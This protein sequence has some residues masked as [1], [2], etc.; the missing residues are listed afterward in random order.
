MGA[1]FNDLF[2]ASHVQAVALV[3]GGQAKGDIGA[4]RGQGFDQQ[5][6][7]RL[8]VGV[9]IAPDGDPFALLDS[10]AQALN[11]AVEIGQGKG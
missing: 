1:G 4:Q 6:C 9:K 5:G 2:Q 3:A 8:A 10:L 11:R 7:G